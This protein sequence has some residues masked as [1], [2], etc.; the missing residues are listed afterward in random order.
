MTT[1]PP[2]VYADT[3]NADSLGRLRLNRVGTARD[4][5]RL[6]IVLRDGLRLCLHDDEELE[7]EGMVRF[8]PESNG[9]TA[10]VD[11]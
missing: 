2:R 1:D 4:L 8:D 9:R 10:V 7:A 3:Q 11:W 6:R 5:A